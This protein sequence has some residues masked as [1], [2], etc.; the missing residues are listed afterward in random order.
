MKLLIL[1]IDWDEKALIII[2][3][4][5]MKIEWKFYLKTKKKL[6]QVSHL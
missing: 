1:I 6:F 3:I 4:Q 2:Q 5:I